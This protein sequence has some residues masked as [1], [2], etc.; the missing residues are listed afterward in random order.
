M[1]NRVTI[2]L[3]GIQIHATL[4]CT[5]TAKLV[6]EALPIESCVNLW[7][8]EI[9]FQ[10]PVDESVENGKS[11][12]EAGTLAYWPPGNALCIF[13]GPTPASTG[14]EI[15]PSSPV[16]VVG[17]VIGNLNALS[18]VKSNSLVKIEPRV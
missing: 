16:T 7:G 14:E 2:S 10:I 1:T 4:N 6:W 8:K 12:V 9:Y 13:Y 3:P 17:Q 5:L 11:T 18:Q 15:R